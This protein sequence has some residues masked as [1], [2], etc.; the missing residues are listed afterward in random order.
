MQDINK[1]LTDI[2]IKIEEKNR[3][4]SILSKLNDEKKEA[5][6]KKN[7]LLKQ[8]NKERKDVE[9]LENLSL[10]NFIQTIIGKKDEKLEKE[11]SEFLSAK[12]KYD[13]ADAEV[14]RLDKEIERVN[15]RISEIGDLDNE[16]QSLIKE[17]EKIL[18]NS[19]REIK[20]KLDNINERE[21]SL[22]K[23]NMEIREA[24]IA[25][26]EV[27]R[28]LDRVYDALKSAKNWGTFDMLGGGML[29]GLVK[30]GKIDKAQAEI[31]KT[32]YLI[33]KFHREL[34]DIGGEVNLSI[35]ISSFLKFADLFF[36]SFF[37]DMFVQSKIQ[38][39]QRDVS[40]AKGKVRYVINELKKRYSKN[41]MEIEKLRKEREEI[42]L[43]F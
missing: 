31:N 13:T 6:S 38:E 35:E 32:Q 40:R 20:E 15:A 22:E 7:K 25:G 5:V 30:H 9:K 3:L 39:S 1:K 14:K 17:K 28:S 36:D 29:S 43:N 12:L 34:N 18:I 21:V 8:L 37:T 10:S 27:L 33:K 16:Y 2:R 11:K 24:I 19:S 23:L 41:N 4:N 42:T 26:E